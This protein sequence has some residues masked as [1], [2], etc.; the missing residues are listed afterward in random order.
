MIDRFEGEYAVFSNFAWS[1]VVMEDLTYDTVEHAF[2]AAKTTDKELRKKFWLLGSPGEAKKLGR[3]IQ[4][5]EDWEEI[6]DGVM[7]ALLRQK[8]TKYLENKSLLIATG[9]DTLVEGN[10]WHDNYW[11]VCICRTCEGKGGKN[12]LGELL[13][14]VRSEI[15]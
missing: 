15:R 2:Q 9:K 6:K 3:S 10:W 11:G 14:Q 7:L 4:L 5:R 13:M 8:F 12:R 1:P